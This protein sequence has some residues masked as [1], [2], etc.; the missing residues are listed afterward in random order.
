MKC[1]ICS[2]DMAC[3]RRGDVEVDTCTGCHAVFFDPGE[4]NYTT[5]LL[6][7]IEARMA[8]AGNDGTELHANCPRCHTDMDLVATQHIRMARCPGC[9]GLMLEAPM[10]AAVAAAAYGPVT[11][12]ERAALEAASDDESVFSWLWNGVAYLLGLGG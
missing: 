7:G 6:P 4:L 2:A 1:A 9:R 3:V 11:R 5:S 8:L 10:V 12:E